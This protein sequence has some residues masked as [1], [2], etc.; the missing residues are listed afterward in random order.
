MRNPQIVDQIDPSIRINGNNIQ[1]PIGARVDSQ[2][3]FNDFVN[4]IIGR[5]NFD[6]FVPELLQS[7]DR[8]LSTLRESPPESP[9][10][11]A[12]VEEIP[13]PPESNRLLYINIVNGIFSTVL[14]NQVSPISLDVSN[15]NIRTRAGTRILDHTIQPLGLIF[16]VIQVNGRNVTVTIGAYPNN[17]ANFDSFVNDIVGTSNYS[18]Y[19]SRLI[20]SFNSQAQTL[21]GQTQ[22]LTEQTR[23]ITH[24]TLNPSR[25]MGTVN[26]IFRDILSGRNT[27]ILLDVSDFDSRTRT[28]VRRYTSLPTSGLIYPVIQLGSGREVTIPIGANPNNQIN[29]EYFVNDIIG[30]SNYTNY[31]HQMIYSF[32]QQVQNRPREIPQLPISRLTPAQR[33]LLSGNFD[34]SRFPVVATIG[35]GTTQLPTIPPR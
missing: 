14:Q 7:F 33:S 26:S 23:P 20:N 15:Y 6:Q 9:V 4:T 5:S 18:Q 32:N 31:V 12:P 16:P 2:R 28:G 30:V 35:P 19:V 17:S 8:Q 11:E 3:N 13:S 24:N 1:I 34:P 10:E 25:Y 27:D 22:R 21:T 29:F